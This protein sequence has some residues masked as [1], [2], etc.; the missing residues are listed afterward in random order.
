MAAVSYWS[1]TRRRLWFVCFL[2]ILGWLI[3]TLFLIQSFTPFDNYQRFILDCATISRS[4]TI[5]A[6]EAR[7][8]DRGWQP[9][10]RSWDEPPEGQSVVRYS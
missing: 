9:V 4:E 6:F 2:P 10:G 7:M 5:D 8:T 3:L 1:I